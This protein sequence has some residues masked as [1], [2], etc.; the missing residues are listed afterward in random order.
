M[1]SPGDR[2]FSRCLHL[3]GR[4]PLPAGALSKRIEE[5]IYVPVYDRTGQVSQGVLAVVELL[6]RW[7]SHDTMI[8]ANAIS[9]MTHLLDAL[10]LSI[11]NPHAQ[12]EQQAPASGGLAA[13][14]AARA[15]AALAHPQPTSQASPPAKRSCQP[16][17][18][19][20]HGLH[21]PHHSINS[22]HNNLGWGEAVTTGG[23]GGSLGMGMGRSMSMRTFA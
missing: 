18:V 7:G 6:I 4:D 2:N 23:S 11:S 15:A 1:I 17:T 3:P 21:S 5:C 16:G 10:H 13:S 12:Q 8:V 20:G 14:A 22:L 19:G 9:C